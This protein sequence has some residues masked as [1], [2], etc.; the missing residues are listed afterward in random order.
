MLERDDMIFTSLNAI[1]LLGHRS[2]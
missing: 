2:V 1:T